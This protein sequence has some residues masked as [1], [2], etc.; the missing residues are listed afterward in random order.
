M[1]REMLRTTTERGNDFEAQVGELLDRLRSSHPNTVRVR[2]QPE[3]TLQNDRRMKPDFE[4]TISLPH[5]TD[6][7]LIE[8]Q[9]RERI[10][11]GIVDKIESLKTHSDRN[12]VLFVYANEVGASVANALN[13]SGVPGLTLEEFQ[14]FIVKTQHTLANA[15]NM[16]LAGF[17]QSAQVLGLHKDPVQ[18]LAAPTQ[19][20]PRTIEQRAAPPYQTRTL[21]STETHGGYHTK[22]PPSGPE[23]RTK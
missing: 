15:Q 20:L 10:R 17:R 1:C 23:Y 22:G 21:S 5:K 6:V 11:P 16:T 7:Y 8:C 19:P 3:L 13:A 9:D 14:D 4:L 2:R 18:G 12:L